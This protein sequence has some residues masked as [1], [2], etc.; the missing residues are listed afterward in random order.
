MR[1][2]RC[3]LCHRFILSAHSTGSFLVK[4]VAAAAVLLQW[5]LQHGVGVIPRSTDPTRIAMNRAAVEE[6]RKKGW[7]PVLGDDD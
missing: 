2:D 5:A 1:Q 3:D 4:S 6:A 7:D